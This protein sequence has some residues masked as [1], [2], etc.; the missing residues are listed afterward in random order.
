[1]MVASNLVICLTRERL[2]F[3]NQVKLL[4]LKSK[5][6]YGRV[7]S[8]LVGPE[9]PGSDMGQVGSTFREPGL[10]FDGPGPNI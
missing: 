2:E 7:A 1:M 6:S 4:H 5:F 8:G 9:K 10:E 3:L